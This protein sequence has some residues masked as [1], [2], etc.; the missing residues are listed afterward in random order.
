M[1]PALASPNDDPSG[2]LTGTGGGATLEADRV[3]HI[4]ADLQMDCDS[5]TP[6]LVALPGRPR[7]VLNVEDRKTMAKALLGHVGHDLDLRM[8]SELRRLRERVRELEAEISH[9]QAA[10]AA[11]SS[12]LMLDDDML[13]LSVPDGV[14]P[15]REPA[16][17]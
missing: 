16:L 10:N 2:L 17:T 13:T 1:P 12:G 11:L 7:P 3:A 5:P 6:S 4:A 9:L 8:V 15:Q 14:A